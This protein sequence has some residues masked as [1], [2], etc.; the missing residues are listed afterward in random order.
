ME[1]TESKLNG[2]LTSQDVTEYAKANSNLK[3]CHF[4]DCGLRG[5]V[6]L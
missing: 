6:C 4:H 5:A 3:L 2:L 1:Q